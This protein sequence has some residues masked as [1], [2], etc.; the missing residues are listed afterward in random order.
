MND[1]FNKYNEILELKN[2]KPI[3]WGNNNKNLEDK[4]KILTRIN[5]KKEKLKNLQEKKNDLKIE[6]DLFYKGYQNFIDLEK[7][8]INNNINL[9]EKIKSFEDKKKDLKKK[10]RRF[11]KR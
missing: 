5:E 11:G 10:K 9:E 8:F 4:M 7:I 6:K 2:Y 3:E 1:C